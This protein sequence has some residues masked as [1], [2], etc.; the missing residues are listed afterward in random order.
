MEAQGEAGLRRSAQPDLVAAWSITGAAISYHHSHP[1]DRCLS[2]SDLR[3][4]YKPGVDEIWAHCKSGI[5]YGARIS[6]DVSR[7]QFEKEHEHLNNTISEEMARVAAQD[8]HVTLSDGTYRNLSDRAFCEALL[9]ANLLDF[10]AVS[11]DGTALPQP[12]DA[13]YSWLVSFAGDILA[14]RYPPPPVT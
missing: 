14:R 3:S 10:E 9:K 13:D 8:S 12:S 2:P 1:D 11:L 5:S 6:A 7:V 4:L